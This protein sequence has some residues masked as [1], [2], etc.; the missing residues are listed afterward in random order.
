M[1]SDERGNGMNVPYVNISHQNLALKE[2]LLKAASR[3]LEHGQLINGPEV[4]QLEEKIADYLGVK[5]VVGV[6]SGTAALYL[7]LRALG[8]GTGDEVITVANSY[9]ATV[10]SIVL[11]GATPIL[12]DVDETMNI[13]P[14]KIEKLITPSTKAI[15]PVHFTG[16]PAAMDQILEIAERNQLWVVEDAAQ[17]IGAKY[18]GRK[19]GSL[20]KLGCFSLHPLKN[21]A[22]LGDG[23]L[24]ATNDVQIAD[25]LRKARNHGHP[26]RDE[27]DFWSFNMRLDTLQAAFILEKLPLLEAMTEQRRY[28]AKLYREHLQETDLIIPQEEAYERCVYHLFMVR[29]P[30]RDILQEHLRANGIESKIHYPTPIHQLKA[31]QHLPYCKGSL[32]RTERFASEILS[33]PIHDFLTEDNYAEIITNIQNFTNK[34]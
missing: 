26:S 28:G 1:G 24:I 30:Q 34:F 5:K 27:C 11:T 31:A 8:I 20:G 14:L 15:L 16:K 17:A 21:L 33:L 13:D 6:A 29:S 2:Q 18:K 22:A 4:E 32:P 3:V 10:S 19:V 12:A 23:G 9:L 7:S 25:W